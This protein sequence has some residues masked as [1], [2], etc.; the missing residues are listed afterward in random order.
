MAADNAASKASAKSCNDSGLHGSLADPEA[1]KHV[2]VTK[3]LVTLLGVAK[4]EQVS[5]AFSS[6]PPLGH[7]MVFAGIVTRCWELQQHICSCSQ[8]C[9]VPVACE[10]RTSC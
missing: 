7:T 1:Y 10:D 5:H 4:A 6:S 2:E 8:T 3:Q 9:C